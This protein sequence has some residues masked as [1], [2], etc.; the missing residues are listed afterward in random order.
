[1]IL[2]SANCLHRI[3]RLLSILKSDTFRTIRSPGTLRSGSS[4]MTR[5]DDADSTIPGHDRFRN[6]HWRMRGG[7]RWKSH[8]INLRHPEF[9]SARESWL[10]NGLAKRQHQITGVAVGNPPTV[11]HCLTAFSLASAELGV[12]KTPSRDRR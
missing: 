10:Q 12:Q 1:M 2:I 11:P 3:F 6:E 9:S 4:G 7:S 5:T 8:V